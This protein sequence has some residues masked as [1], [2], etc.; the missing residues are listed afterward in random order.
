MLN[1]VWKSQ[2]TLDF[3][4]LLVVVFFL[5]HN[6]CDNDW[7]KVCKHAKI[8][9][10]NGK[11]DILQLSLCQ[12]SITSNDSLGMPLFINLAGF[13]SILQN[14]FAPPPPFLLNIW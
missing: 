4:M 1:K 14:T 5:D 8:G 12:T 13:F 10:G 3:R 6:D 2:L 7:M 9:G 11:S